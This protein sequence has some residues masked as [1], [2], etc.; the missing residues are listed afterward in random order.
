MVYTLIEP[1]IKEMM[2]KFSCPNHPVR[3]ILTGPSGCRNLV[4]LTNLVLNIINEYDKICVYSRSLHEDLYQKLLIYFSNF[5]TVHKFSNILNEE[6]VDIVIDEIVSNKNFEK[7]DIEIETYESIEE[8]KY[9]QEY[10]DGG[11]IILEVLNE[12]ERIDPRVQALFEQ[13]RH[14]DLSLF[15][16]SQDYYEFPKR[17]IPANGN[18]YHILNQKISEMYKVFF[19]IKPLS[20]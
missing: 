10:E 18:M 12:Q 15:I 9:P 4:F 2:D 5:I 3:C 14:N 1:L 16:T 6:D 7:S 11:N 20:I 8:L 19:K 13:S 17:T